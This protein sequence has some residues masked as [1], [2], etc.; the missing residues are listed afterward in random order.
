MYGQFCEL[1]AYESEENEKIQILSEKELEEK[2]YL[3][4]GD[5]DHYNLP[6][7]LVIKEPTEGDFENLPVGTYLLYSE[8]AY[9]SKFSTS[10][11][12]ISIYTD[13]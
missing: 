1:H 6:F 4:C 2:V 11:G 10:N 3:Y 5:I 8:S 13:G 12:G 9:I 7:I